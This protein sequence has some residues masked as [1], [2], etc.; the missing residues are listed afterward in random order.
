MT[1]DAGSLTEAAGQPSESAVKAKQS[2]GAR[3]VEGV[4]GGLVRV[5]L[6][7]VGLFWLVPTIGLLLSS[8]RTPRDMAAGGWWRSSP[9][10]PSSPSGATRSC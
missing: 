6:I 4:S 5:F 2:L 1:A 3:L 7:V 10:R 9:S 8:L